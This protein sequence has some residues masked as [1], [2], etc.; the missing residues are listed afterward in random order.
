MFLNL[1]DTELKAEYLKRRQVEV[2]HREAEQKPGPENLMMQKWNNLT[3]HVGLVCLAYSLITVVKQLPGGSVEYV[4]FKPF[5]GFFCCFL[6]KIF[7]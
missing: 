6:Y 5:R 7:D 3:N 4:K 2:F 1:A